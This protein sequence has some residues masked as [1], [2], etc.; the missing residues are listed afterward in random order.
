MM[1]KQLLRMATGSRMA[2]KTLATNNCYNV[3]DDVLLV[4]PLLRL[5]LPLPVG[6]VDQLI[7][8]STDFEAV[9]V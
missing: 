5:F 4:L 3:L 6:T 2:G 9:A 7:F 1:A 8:T